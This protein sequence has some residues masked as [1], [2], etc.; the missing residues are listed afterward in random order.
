MGRYDRSADVKNVKKDDAGGGKSEEASVNVGL[1]TCL[2]GIGR[3]KQQPGM[4]P[5]N[6]NATCRSDYGYKS[7]GFVWPDRRRG[8]ETLPL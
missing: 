1:S 4:S 5:E 7:G 6:N 2:E 3:L 8:I